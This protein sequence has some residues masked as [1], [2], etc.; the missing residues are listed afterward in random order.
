MSNPL[1]STARMSC[2]NM[3]PLPYQMLSVPMASWVGVEAGGAAVEAP[4]AGGR[5]HERNV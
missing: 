3:N 2:T 1:R 5:R 4:W